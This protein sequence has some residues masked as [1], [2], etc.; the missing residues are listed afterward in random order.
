MHPVTLRTTDDD[1]STATTTRLVAVGV[2]PPTECRDTD[3][4][5]DPDNDG[6]GLCDHW[7]TDEIDVDDDG[8]VDLALHEPPY[9]ADPNRKDIFV[10][11]DYMDCEEGGCQSGDTHD[12]EPDPD[13]LRAVRQSFAD[14]SV[15]NPDGTTGITLHTMQDEALREVTPLRFHGARTQ[16]SPAGTFDELKHGDPDTRCDG[17]FGTP[18]NHSGSNCANALQARQLV[19]HYAATITRT[20]P[21]RAASPKSTV[22]ISS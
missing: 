1:G 2:S 19:F 22:T 4:N 11:I 9:D 15:E 18:A 6:D 13:A 7:E 3:G 21:G 10:E 20:T 14:A 17:H 8:T 16:V 12:H 5:G